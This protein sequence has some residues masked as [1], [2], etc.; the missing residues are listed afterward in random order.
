MTHLLVL[1]DSGIGLR[2]V[3]VD[4]SLRLCFALL[5]LSFSQQLRAFVL[6]DLWPTQRQNVIFNL[7][8]AH[9]FPLV[10]S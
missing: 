2:F 4:L 9:N 8:F 10:L 3:N 1:H 6:S 5:S 7:S